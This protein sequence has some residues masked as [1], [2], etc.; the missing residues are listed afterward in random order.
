MDERAA[1]F[2]ANRLGLVTR[3]P[4]E[5]ARLVQQKDW[6]QTPLGPIERWPESLRLSV[7]LILASGFPMA[8]RWGPELISIYNDAY[9]RILGD[10]HPHAL[11]QPAHV[12]WPEIANELI[13][14]YRSIL[15][16]ERSAFFAKDHVWRVRRHGFFEDAHFTI[17]YSPIPE[18]RARNGIGGVL[19][20][21]TETTAESRLEQR[22]RHLT[23]KLEE[24][25][26]LRTRER[27]RIWQVSEDLL[28]VGNFE[29]YYLSVNP[30][31][32]AL[33]GWSDE[34]IKRMHVSE[35]RH[36]DDA[37]AAIAQR[38]RLAAG[39]PTVRM[40]N[41]FRHKD[42][43]WRWLHWTLSV[44]DGLIYVIGRHVTAEKEAAE[45]LRES[46]RE[47][48][49]L[50]GAVTDYAI[51]KLTPEGIVSSWNP[52]AERIKGY[53]ASEIIGRHFRTFYTPED[54][55]A[56]VP[57]RAL[58]AAAAEGRFELEGWRLRK[59]GTRFWANVVIDS[60]YDE[61]GSLTGFAKITRDITERREAQLALERTREQLAQSQKMDALGQLTGGIAH[62]FNNML[63]VVGGYTQF[64]KQRLTNPKEKRAVDAIEFAAS[65]GQNLTRQ[66][67]TFSRRQSLN[68]VTVRLPECFEAMRDILT[69]T[70]K[71]NVTLDIRIPNGVWP[72]TID[73]NEFEVAIINLL[74]NAR[75]AMPKGGTI[76][77][78]ARNETIADTSE[79]EKL[80]GDFVVIEVK[81][82]GTGIAPEI[83]PRVFDPFFTTKGTDKGTGL[84]L[85]QVYG[86]AHQAGGTVRIASR[87]DAGT[88]VTLYLPR[89]K[90]TVSRVP[91]HDSGVIGGDEVVL[92]VEDNADVQTIVSTML[93]Q[94]GYTVVLADGVAH[95]LKVLEAGDRV[96]LVL[97]D[98]IMP[99]PL[100]GMAL[101]QHIAKE[102]PQIPVL[103]TTGYAAAD[104][105]RSAFPVLRKPYQLPAL[106][107]AVRS[108][109][110]R[111]RVSG[112]FG[113]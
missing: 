84:G 51:F 21:A 33:L 41:R 11:G 92:L 79:P 25:V 78:S 24:E 1:S 7:D 93:E 101:A 103:L 109:L 9:A 52:G 70:A 62:D 67:L 43:S 36:P 30:A 45:R 113:V 14:L 69:A 10:K 76:A 34:E 74:V 32:S 85:S 28:A 58:A 17:S 19:V 68:R 75:D 105:A 6:S 54:R 81:D 48:R 38:A 102:Y 98:V 100:D 13:P 88:T 20:T 42:G 91:K 95:A 90:E 35:L 108:A 112:S 23:H 4:G 110:N 89:A 83:M 26:T 47:F 29:G 99:G 37:P 31:W 73:V 97:T 59:D 3:L 71:G 94:L 12:V 8:L 2:G 60:I 22:L 82:E 5:M 27:D 107:R 61:A 104:A 57:E 64:L 40:E 87:P 86:F 15:C 56:G 77:I 49:S 53:A 80:N 18:P 111:G 55:D 72:V 63:M 66:L 106:A 50:V 96:D 44:D 65:R 46:E 39:V 16:G